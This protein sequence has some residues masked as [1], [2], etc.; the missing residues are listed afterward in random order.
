MEYNI[1]YNINK[2][3]LEYIE[4]SLI[5]DKI[6]LLEYRV[7]TSEDIEY[8]EHIEHI[9]HIKKIDIKKIDKNILKLID[10]NFIENIKKY[11][12]SLEYKIPLYDI[13]TSNIYIINKENIYIRVYYNYYRFPTIKLIKELEKEY[14]ILQKQNLKDPLDIRK[15][16]KYE[17]MLNFMKNFDNKIL[18]D[19]YYRMIYKYSEKFGKN[20]IFCKRP[21]FNKYIHN[22]RPYYTSTEIINLA[23]N[24]NIKFDINDKIFDINN[25][26]DIVKQNDIDYKIISDHQKYIINKDL[27]GLVQYYTIQG[28]FFVN[29]YL[30]NLVNYKCRNE[31]LD[32]III[33]MWK[34]CNTA[35][36]FDKDYILYRFIQNDSHLQYLKLGDIYQDNGFL[37]TTRDPFYRSDTYDFGLILMKIKI[38]KNI[39]GVAL[40]VEMVSHFPSEQEI[41][42][43]PKSKFKLISRDDNTLYYHTDPNFSSKVKTRYEFEWISNVE[44]YID[45]LDCNIETKSIDFLKIIP[46][47]KINFYDSFDDFINKYADKMIRIKCIIGDKEYLSVI[48]K[49]NS[50]GAYKDFYALHT[51]NG[52]SIYS[53]YNNYILFF[54][55]IGYNDKEILEMHVNY[56]VKYN[57][58]NKENIINQYD[59]IKFIASVGYYFNVDKI[60]IYPEYKPCVIGTKIEQRN[61]DK[62]IEENV[63]IDMNITKINTNLTGNYCYDFY[64]YYKYNKKR[65]FIEN[66]NEIELNPFFTYY[67]LDYLKEIDINK[68]LVKSDD[69]L[70]QIYDKAYKIDFPNNK[71]A[72][73]LIW[74]IDNKCYLSESLISKFDRIYK[75][76][77]PFKRDFYISHPRIFLYNKGFI[78][79]YGNTSIEIDF[80][81]RKMY[82]IPTNEY[83]VLNNRD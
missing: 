22:T 51:N 31:F 30:R 37:S 78:K 15:K 72:D 77:N 53:I 55:E 6:Y 82:K 33:S 16:R 59:F 76:F 62:N 39:K 41:L 61:Y 23:L 1:L 12:S 80:K 50:I 65:F 20:I 18:E 64:K 47:N 14:Q 17:L 54:I 46:S 21:S 74:I 43:S 25:I 27:L 34:L 75:S 8:I 81:E 66:L 19:T 57:T 24:M 5:M 29:S 73:F 38:P 48:E 42:F 13:Y 35:P 36:E 79:I 52:I 2:N 58:L 3:I 60:A 56:Y 45:K 70:Y 67:D 63:N 32:N 71:M 44:P 49:Y 40:C 68:I 11:I 7:P 28:S 26:C 10:D 9:E 69:E 4:P 83:R